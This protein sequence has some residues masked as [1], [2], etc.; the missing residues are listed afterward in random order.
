MSDA[1]ASNDYEM[2]T[3]EGGDLEWWQICYDALP[4]SKKADLKKYRVTIIYKT[5]TVEF[6]LKKKESGMILGGGHGR[7]VVEKSSRSVSELYF[8]R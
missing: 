5:E 1:E 3:I 2:T 4:D 8:S 7:C 6:F